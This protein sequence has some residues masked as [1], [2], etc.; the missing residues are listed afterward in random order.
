MRRIDYKKW[1]MLTAL[2]LSLTSVGKLQAQDY[3]V[4]NG[5]NGYYDYDHRVIERKVVKCTENYQDLW[6]GCY[7]KVNGNYSYV[8]DGSDRILYGTDIWLMPSGW[9]VVSYDNDKTERLVDANGDYY[10]TWGYD[11]RSFWTGLYD[12][13][14]GGYWKLYDAYGNYQGVY[15]DDP[16]LVFWNGY[17]SY[18]LNGYEYV[19]DENG[20]RVSGLYGDNIT[21][22]N[23][24]N[25]RCQRG[26]Y[27]YIYDKYG[28]R[29]D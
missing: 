25:F 1:L 15:S 7:V 19:A 21:L 22:M 27:Y 28:N 12:V 16:I 18:H 3:Y 23:N 14:I 9:Y 26:D 20:D 4:P 2:L 29:V 8:Y 24:G 13:Y 11:I 5:Y 10:G 6:N 17:Y